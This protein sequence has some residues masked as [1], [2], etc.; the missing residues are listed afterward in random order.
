[1][2]TPSPPHTQPNTPH[3]ST[4]PLH[5][6]LISH[7]ASDSDGGGGGGKPFKVLYGWPGISRDRVARFLPY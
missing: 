1:M 2:A 3:P 5:P 4:K 6:S 7:L